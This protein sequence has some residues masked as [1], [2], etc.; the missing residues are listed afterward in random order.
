MKKKPSTPTTKPKET[1]KPEEPKV[2][3]IQI[4]KK[5]GP[6]PPQQQQAP[7]A[8]PPKASSPP[9][10]SKKRKRVMVMSDSSDE[11]DDDN[12]EQKGPPMLSSKRM[13]EKRDDPAKSTKLKDS[14]VKKPDLISNRAHLENSPKR[15]RGRPPMN[16]EISRDL[17]SS[18]TTSA[19]KSPPVNKDLPAGPS[20]RTEAVRQEPTANSNAV[21]VRASY[22]LPALKMD[23]SR[24]YNF[25]LG[26]GAVTIQVKNNVVP[27]KLHE[28][29][30][31]SEGYNWSALTSSSVLTVGA[32]KEI[33]VVVCK[34]GSLHLFHPSQRG[35]RLVPPMQLPSPVSKVSLN[36]G[37]FA[38]ATTC[39]H[40]YIWD[41]DPKPRIIMKKE[42]IQSLLVSS[43][44]EQTVTI[45]KLITT[46]EVIIITSCGKKTV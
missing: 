12:S 40:L 38:A 2:N 1:A 3:I 28:I 7:V 42:D 20:G 33:I 37:R 18:P 16:R 13:D 5:P 14:K 21:T 25:N 27:S 39:A 36:N 6:A 35:Q 23:K 31:I 45:A 30:C 43:N 26:I 41:L 22:K 19:A 24:V 17:N 4:K 46:P 8:S 15:P 34:N 44:S 10:A 9:M 32:S 29:K 11:D